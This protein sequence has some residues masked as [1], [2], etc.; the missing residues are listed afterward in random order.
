MGVSILQRNTILTKGFCQILSNGTDG[1]RCLSNGCLIW[2]GKCNFDKGC[3]S[4]RTDSRKGGHD[5]ALAPPTSVLYSYVYVY[6]LVNLPR[7]LRS[8]PRFGRC[9]QEIPK[10]IP[11]QKCVSDTLG[12]RYDNNLIFFFLIAAVITRQGVSLKQKKMSL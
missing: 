5:P 10:T 11:H 3:L 1:G 12:T 8:A 6:G 9:E 7:L 4:N 2:I